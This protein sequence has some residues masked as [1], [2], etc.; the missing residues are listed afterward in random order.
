MSENYSLSE[1]ETN[2]NYDRSE[3]LATVFTAN[4]AVV[5]KLDK[6]MASRGNEM[7]L[8]HK[9]IATRT[10]QI[11]KKWVKITPSRILSDEQREQIRVRF[12][13]AKNS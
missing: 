2:I 6:L 12:Q 1:Q 11:P 5:R 3:S 7:I 13:N 9:T 4:P 8:V 10:Y